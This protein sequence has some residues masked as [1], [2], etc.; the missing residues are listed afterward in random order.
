MASFACNAVAPR[1]QCDITRKA[2]AQKRRTRVCEQC[3][4]RFIERGRSSKQLQEGKKQRFCSRACCDTSR[5][6]YQS[7]QEQKRASK[8][9]ECERRQIKLI[10]ASKTLCAQ[11]GVEFMQPTLLRIY[12][13]KLCD[14]CSNLDVPRIT[15]ACAECHREF[16]PWGGSWR[17]KY[18]SNRCLKKA[19]GRTGKLKRKARIAETV[20]RESVNVFD[21]FERDGW[22]CHIC[23]RRTP[24][25]LR[26]TTDERAPE[27]DHL[28]PLSVG[29]GHTYGNTACACRAC[30]IK[31]AA[32]PFGQ[33][34]LFPKMGGAIRF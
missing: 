2:N 12:W 7:R 27:L 6:K 21:V 32:T 28:V 16:R 1:R 23:H 22:R 3:G 9:R 26:G 5:R 30:N 24:R 11:C 34:H 14:R 10:A 17:S 33:L 4:A 20:R 31:K 29:G 19:S 15:V 8:K 13:T 18:C 25:N